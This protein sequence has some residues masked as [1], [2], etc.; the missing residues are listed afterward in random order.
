M[1]LLKRADNL[2]H[3]FIKPT[4]HEGIFTCLQAH[5]YRR[6]QRD[7]RQDPQ[8]AESWPGNNAAWLVHLHG[9]AGGAA[10]P[11]GVHAA[12]LP[13]DRG[14]QPLQVLLRPHPGHPHSLCNCFNVSAGPFTTGH[15]RTFYPFTPEGKNVFDE[16]CSAGRYLGFCCRQHD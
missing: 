6:E 3:I 11:T 1:K 4:L 12:H 10:V 7:C 9:G 13:G 15:P 14:A 8:C 16:V 2:Y 5:P